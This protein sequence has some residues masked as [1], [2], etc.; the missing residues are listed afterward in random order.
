LKLRVFNTRY[1]LVEFITSGELRWLISV[2]GVY[3]LGFPTQLSSPGCSFL[4]S[5]SHWKMESHI[6]KHE[7][8]I[9]LSSL[10]FEQICTSKPA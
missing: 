5:Y 3:M 1:R 10:I 8:H 2:W 6:S 9:M 4:C 7:I